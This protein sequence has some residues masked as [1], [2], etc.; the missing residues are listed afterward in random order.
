MT[1]FSESRGDESLCILLG[2]SL[3]SASMIALFPMQRVYNLIQLQK[4]SAVKTLE[5]VSKLTG[6]NPALSF[7]RQER[8]SVSDRR[9]PLVSKTN[10]LTVE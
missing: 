2:L 5:S 7:Q 8:S 4:K 1:L 3:M 9:S 6:Q 10:T